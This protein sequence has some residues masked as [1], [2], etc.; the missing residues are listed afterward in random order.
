M[1]PCRAPASNSY[2]TSERIEF[3]DLDLAVAEDDRVLEAVGLG[4]DQVAQRLALVPRLGA[5]LDQPL[6]DVGA[7]GG[8]PG[9]LDAH[10]RVQELLRQLGD[11]RRHGGREEQRLAGEGQHLADALDVGNEAHVEHAV[12]LVDDEDLDRVEKQLAALAVVHQP[13]RRRDQH[14]GA[15]LELA[16]S[17]SSKDT[18][19]MRRAMFSLWFLP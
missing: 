9:D 17:C 14:V 15:A 7:G 4:V 8:G 5:G 18:P 6:R 13:A 2:L 3:R 11:L 12:R 1:S 19:P 16:C 10:R